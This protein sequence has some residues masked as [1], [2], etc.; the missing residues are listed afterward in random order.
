MIGET[1][2]PAF[3]AVAAAWIGRGLPVAVRLPS[4]VILP[5]IVMNLT[6]GGMPAACAPL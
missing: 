1:T 6:I 2:N 4:T 3:I 5:V